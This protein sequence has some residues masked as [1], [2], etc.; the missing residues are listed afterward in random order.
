MS[1]SIELGFSNDEV[2]STRFP[3]HRACRDGDVRALCSLLQRSDDR[4]QLQAED[5]FYGWTPIHWA[6]HFG[7]LECVLRLVQVGCE[8]NAVTTRFLQTPAH[9]AAF[10]GH[11]ECLVWLLQA[12]AEINRQDY[13]GEAPIHKA[14]RAGSMDC[15]NALLFSGAKPELRN[16]NGL[17]AAD[18]AHAQG[19]QDCAQLL[20]NAE[21]QLKHLNGF[22]HNGTDLT[23]IQGR[24]LLNGLTNRKR[25]H[26][27]SEPNH[28]KKARVDGM[29]F[30]VKAVSVMEEDIECMHVESAPDNQ[31]DGTIEIATGLSNGHTQQKSF[32]TNGHCPPHQPD[33]P[34]LGSNMC[35]SLHLSGSPSSYMS[36]RPLW[37]T[38]SSDFSDHLHYGHYHGFGD[39][40]E[41]L[42][43][44][45]SRHE[46]ITTVK[47]EQHY[48]QEVLNAMQL[49]HGS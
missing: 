19:F 4:A 7:K 43:D 33:V 6:A 36:H 32:D 1:V 12:G 26:D 14:A 5:S 23:H 35:G 31:S 16:T 34:D 44:T 18:L 46:H 10:G 9:I 27:C 42:E 39:T 15:I 38:F 13:M 29:D 11:P 17:T 48:N 22:G 30:P 40:A 21:N 2:L 49:F 25:L 28:V 3:L 47:L 24:S 8:V 41:D 37:A 20:S 45:G